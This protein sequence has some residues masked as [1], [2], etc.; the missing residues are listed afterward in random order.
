MNPQH[1]C[2]NLQVFVVLKSFYPGFAEQTFRIVLTSQKAVWE[3]LVQFGVKPL[4]TSLSPF[5]ESQNVCQGHKQTFLQA[6]TE[7]LA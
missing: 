2:Q 5:H 4:T 3:F 1:R 7:N 6:W